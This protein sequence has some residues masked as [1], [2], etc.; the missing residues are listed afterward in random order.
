MNGCGENVLKFR[1]T[2]I[3]QKNQ[4]PKIKM[5]LERRRRSTMAWSK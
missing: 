1:K 5:T 3:D 2:F 4:T